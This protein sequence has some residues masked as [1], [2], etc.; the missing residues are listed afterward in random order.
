MLYFRSP[1]DSSI[2]SMMVDT[3][4]DK[5]NKRRCALSISDPIFIVTHG[6][7]SRKL[8]Q[9]SGLFLKIHKGGYGKTPL[10]EVGKRA[11]YACYWHNLKAGAYKIKAVFTMSVDISAHLLYRVYKQYM[12]KRIWSGFPMCTIF[13][14]TTSEKC[15]QGRSAEKEYIR[16]RVLYF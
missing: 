5:W 7:T 15:P 16:H 8:W 13:L 14:F 3:K 9:Y 6:L 12:K 4:F 2:P 11:Q 1:D 10:W